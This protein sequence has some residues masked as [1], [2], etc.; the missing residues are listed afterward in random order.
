[1][2]NYLYFDDTEWGLINVFMSVEVG[3]CL[4]CQVNISF[5][6]NIAS[7]R[8]YIKIMILDQ[9]KDQILWWQ[10]IEQA[11]EWPPKLVVVQKYTKV[12]CFAGYCL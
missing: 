10:G 11:P 5:L 6:M 7:G 1:M 9:K 8:P 12:L 4:A 3:P 2:E